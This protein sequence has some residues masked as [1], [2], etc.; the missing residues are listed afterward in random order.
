MFDF[1]FTPF[2]DLEFTAHEGKRQ[3]VSGNLIG[4]QSTSR[5][6]TFF[7]GSQEEQE[8]PVRLNNGEQIANPILY[9][10]PKNGITIVIGFGID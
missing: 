10:T 3:R 5:D 2:S 7:P 9:R 6:V 8:I 4:L 1:C